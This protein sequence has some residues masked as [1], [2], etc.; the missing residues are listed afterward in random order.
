MPKV[1]ITVTKK[2][3]TK[4]VYGDKFPTELAGDFAPDCPRHNEGEEFL[5]QE[6]GA[7]PPGFC[8]WAYADIQRDITHLGLGG[9]YPWC[10]EKNV[11]ISCCTDGLRPVFFKLETMD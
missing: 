2:L 3:T 10:Q 8:G 4:D 6:D 11:G 5:V 7:C 9:S 1:K